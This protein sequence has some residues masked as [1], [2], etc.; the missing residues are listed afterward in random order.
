MEM[1][2]REM[3]QE[4]LLIIVSILLTVILLIFI[5]FYFKTPIVNILK[6]AINAS[7]KKSATRQDSGKVNLSSKNIFFVGNLVFV[8]NFSTFIYAFLSYSYPKDLSINATGT[9]LFGY[10][11]A[12][13][14][15]YLMFK[16]ISVRLLAW[17]LNSKNVASEYLFLMFANFRAFGVALLPINILIPFV[18]DYTRIGLIV[19]VIILFFASFLIR[20][21]N[22]FLISFQIKFHFH[23]SILYFCTLEIFPI[24]IIVEILGQIL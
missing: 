22:G 12:A 17:I 3:P 15:L 14:G 7:F 16:L 21:I 5:K 19:I 2:S 24:L 6:T 11:F 1:I 20:I 4:R 13:T 23:Y 18:D 8:I 10:I 9:V